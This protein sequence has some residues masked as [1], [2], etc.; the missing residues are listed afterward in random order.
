MSKSLSLREH[1]AAQVTTGRPHSF[2]VDMPPLVDAPLH[3]GMSQRERVEVLSRLLCIEGTLHRLASDV[4]DIGLA[5]SW[6]R[7]E[8]VDDDIDTAIEKVTEAIRRERPI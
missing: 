5:A 1:L 4:S 2:D 8:S 6:L 3:P 7:L